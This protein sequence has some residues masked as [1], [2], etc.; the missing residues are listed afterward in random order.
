MLTK[1]LLLFAAASAT[2]PWHEDNY[3]KAIVEARFRRV[4]LFVEVWAP[5]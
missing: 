4:P 1:L 2:L 3:A 5:W